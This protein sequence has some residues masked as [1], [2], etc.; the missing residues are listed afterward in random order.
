MYVSFSRTFSSL[1]RLN[2]QYFACQNGWL[3]LI[4]WGIEKNMVS[5]H[6]ARRQV[7]AGHAAANASVR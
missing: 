2:E 7:A 3:S 5:N 6:N 1:C 4:F